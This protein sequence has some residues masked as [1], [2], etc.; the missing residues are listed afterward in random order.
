MSELPFTLFSWWL[1]VPVTVAGRQTFAHLDTGARQCRVTKSLA[2]E[3]KAT[4][5]RDAFGVHGQQKV[6]MVELEQ[7]TFMDKAF[8]NL[9]ASVI[10]HEGMFADLPFQVEVV[11]SGDVI[12]AEPIMFDFRNQTVNKQ[13]ADGL[14]KLA[15]QTLDTSS[16]LPFF[17]LQGS[18]AF[19]AAFDL[20][21]SS[22]VIDKKCLE[23]LP[24]AEKLFDVPVPD[25]LG[26]EQMLEFFRVGTVKFQDYELRLEALATDLSS[27]SDVVGKRIDFIF[28]LNSMM[29]G[30]WFSDAAGETIGFT[31]Y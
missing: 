22:T 17:S 10:D 12:L 1:Y 24:A 20:G 8:S 31:P 28:G 4:G 23:N 19:N 16:G 18:E 7:L 11:L 29:Q 21:A 25:T 30:R 2:Q 6:E 15:T 3:L 5:E 14:T 27:L 26:G 9:P 13:S